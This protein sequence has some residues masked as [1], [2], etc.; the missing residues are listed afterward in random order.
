MVTW[1]EPMVAA[2]AA[3]LVGAA[4]APVT[5][6]RYCAGMISRALVAGLIHFAS[7]SEPPPCSA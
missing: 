4:G 1:R 6:E 2:G 7:A 3:G 5:G